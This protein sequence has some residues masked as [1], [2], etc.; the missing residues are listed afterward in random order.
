MLQTILKSFIRPVAEI[1]K[2]EDLK[3]AMTKL[4]NSFGKMRKRT[5]PI[6]I[7]FY[8]ISKLKILKE[9]YLKLLQL[10]MPLQDKNQLK[11]CH[12]SYEE[13][14]MEVNKNDNDENLRQ[15]GPFVIDYDS[16]SWHWRIWLQ[17][18]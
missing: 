5:E 11:E 9:Y 15:H 13:K 10:Y 7:R 14:Y 8:T 18:Q 16:C 12:M 3:S 6:A 17:R 1:H 2:E 4:K